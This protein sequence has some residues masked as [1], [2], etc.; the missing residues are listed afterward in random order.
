MC[1]VNDNVQDIISCSNS[2]NKGRSSRGKH[3]HPNIVQSSQRAA[4]R[5]AEF[6][7]SAHR[8]TT[9][10]FDSNTHALLYLISAVLPNERLLQK[11]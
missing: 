2:K 8:H 3:G 10:L 4:M 6:L 5:P 7:E 11:G 1:L 9:G